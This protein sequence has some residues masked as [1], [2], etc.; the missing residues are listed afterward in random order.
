MISGIKKIFSRGFEQH[1]S[2]KNIIL[3][4]IPRSG[5]TLSC[6]ILL[7][8]ENQIA[9]NEPIAAPLFKKGSPPGKVIRRC[10]S[11]YRKS[12]LKEGVAPVR[13]REGKVTDNAYSSKG[14]SRKKVLERSR[15][16]FDKPLSKDF[17]LILKHCAE[18]TL[19]LEELK[20]EYECYAI[21]RNPLSILASWSSVN[22][23]VSRGKVAKSKL[24]RPDFYQ[25]IE[26]L[27]SLEEKQIFI[28]DWYFSQYRKLGIER[29]IKYE[30]IIKSGGKALS[31][32]SGKEIHYHEELSNK[33]TNKVYDKNSILKYRDLL[34]NNKQGNHLYFYTVEDIHSLAK[35][36]GI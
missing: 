28:L 22:V 24:F 1:P 31:V 15:V 13:T 32:V 16:Y 8:A 36:F 6:K 23:P 2:G 9:L 26:E 29:V 20:E 25:K 11:S 19:I 12:L 17:T 35:Q 27:K 14:S 30:D 3:T 7:C 10:F 18:F 5:T 21:V 4:G 33:N 34:L